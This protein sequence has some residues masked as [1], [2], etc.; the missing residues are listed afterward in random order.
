M[1]KFDHHETE[2]VTLKVLVERAQP[3]IGVIMQSI[4]ALPDDQQNSINALIALRL[5]RGCILRGFLA[6]IPEGADEIARIE[7][8]LDD[9]IAHGDVAFM[10]TPGASG[11]TH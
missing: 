8:G 6:D 1:R 3:A 2:R 9:A 5:V 4:A 10:R 7:A 11:S